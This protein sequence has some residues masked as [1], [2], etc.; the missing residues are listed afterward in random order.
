M[1]SSDTVSRQRAFGGMLGI[2]LLLFA[3]VYR[4]YPELL[5][6]HPATPVP[7]TGSTASSA[8]AG[9]P[10]GF[11]RRPDRSDSGQINA[12]PPLSLAPE[13]VIAAE[14]LAQLGGARS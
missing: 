7:D 6:L 3:L 1:P 5:Y 8:T 11:D 12:G 4:F 9:A 2:A 14:R 10:L 13:Q